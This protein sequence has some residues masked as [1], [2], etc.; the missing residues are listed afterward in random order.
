MENILLIQE[1]TH[2]LHHASSSHS[3]FMVKA[4]IEKTFDRVQWS[5]LEHVLHHF[6]FNI[7]FIH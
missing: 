2:S 7:Q 4:D 3:P 5:Y 6:C 1:L